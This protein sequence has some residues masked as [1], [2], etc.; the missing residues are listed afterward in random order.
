MEHRRGSLICE[1]Q[2]R[3]R[4]WSTEH[5]PLGPHTVKLS[6]GEGLCLGLDALG[7][8]THGPYAAACAGR[9]PLLC[10]YRSEAAPFAHVMFTDARSCHNG[11]M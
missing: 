7:H 1:D 8:H 4:H 6:Q 9:T 2:I 10:A 5:E 11:Y 3:G